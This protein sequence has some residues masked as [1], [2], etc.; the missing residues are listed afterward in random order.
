MGKFKRIV[1]SW[2]CFF[3]SVL[4]IQRRDPLSKATFMKQTLLP[5]EGDNIKLAVW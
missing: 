1:Y 2:H 3:F 5:S 4:S